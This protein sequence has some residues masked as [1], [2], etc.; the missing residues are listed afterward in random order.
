M[1][2]PSQTR[3]PLVLQPNKLQGLSVLMLLTDG[4]GGFGGIAKF[5]RDFLS[6]LDHCD[7]VE[8]VHALPRLIPE[9]FE[10]IIPERVVYD[11]IAA[12][13]R[14]AFLLRAGGHL[15]RRTRVQLVIC[16]HIYLLPVA[17]LLARLRGARLTL[18]IHGI[19]AW[20]P[21]GKFWIGQLIRYIDNFIAVSRFSA[22]KFTAWS[23]V[24]MDRGFILPNC[25]DLDRFRPGHRDP[26]LV[27]R[28]GLQS[29]KVIMTMGRLAAAERYKG[30]DQVIEIMPRLR[31]R[32]PGLKY[33]IIGDGDDRARLEAKAKSFRVFDKA[34]FAGR[35]SESEKVAHYNLADA[36]VMPSTG[37]GFGIVLIEALA[38]GIPVV[39]SKVDGSREAL[40]D[41]RLGAIVDPAQP[42]ELFDAVSAALGKTVPPK[43]IEC[44][45]VFSMQN[46]RNRVANWCH[47]QATLIAA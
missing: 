47:G 17:W 23:E 36:Y 43:R 24:P 25:V 26:R 44:V 12:R 9:K 32:F 22:Q 13:G 30:I 1:A 37:E 18:I 5:N 3:F 29:A 6:A 4:F 35:I 2:S 45:S 34:V 41:G 46:F 27:E 42:D 31:E 28:Y 16:G 40:L 8:R 21:S 38:C 7:H 15:W 11:R 14:L 10:Q 39:G 33:L 20:K 19:E